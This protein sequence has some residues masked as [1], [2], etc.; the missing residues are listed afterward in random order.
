MH[1]TTRGSMIHKQQQMHAIEQEIAAA[2]MCIEKNV[3]YY[4]DLHR[5]TR[6]RQ[7]T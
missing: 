6:F 2:A 5:P 4:T 1:S 7:D 3:K